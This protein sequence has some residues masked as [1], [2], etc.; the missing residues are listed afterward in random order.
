VSSATA[1]A[2]VGIGCRFPGGVVDV[3]SFWRLL[4]QGGDAITEVPA[5][6]YDLAR[7]YNERPATPGRTMSRYGGFVEPIESFDAAFFDIS[8]REAQ[9][10]DPHQR[11]LL[12]VAW[13]ALEDAG[14][15]AAQ[16]STWGS[17]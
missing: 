6:R 13:E 16:A 8:P 3:S 7:F 14:A 10:L 9:T 2:I 4:E 12:E 17:G 11:L 1:I 15:A 5:N